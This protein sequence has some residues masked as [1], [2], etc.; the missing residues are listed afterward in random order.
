MLYNQHYKTLTYTLSMHKNS[1]NRSVSELFIQFYLQHF[2]LLKLMSII[3]SLY[4]LAIIVTDD[5]DQ[6]FNGFLH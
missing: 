2:T 6:L 4:N 3:N 1:Y 5:K